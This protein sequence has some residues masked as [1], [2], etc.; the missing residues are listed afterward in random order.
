MSMIRTWTMACIGLPILICTLSASAYDAETHALIAYQG[1]QAST[2]SSRA[3]GSVVS[4]LGLDRLDPPTPFNTYWLGNG[5]TPGPLS[6]YDNE[7]PTF[8]PN[9]HRRQPQEYE[10]CQFQHLADYLLPPN[11]TSNWLTGDPMLASDKKTVTYFP[12][13]NWLMRRQLPQ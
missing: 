10:R 3:A 4:R 7:G 6:Y 13:E 1:Y 8:D 5:S 9:M 2:L 12:I 11:F